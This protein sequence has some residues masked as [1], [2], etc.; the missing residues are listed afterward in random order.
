MV[1]WGVFLTNRCGELFEVGLVKFVL[2]NVFAKRDVS[3]L[4]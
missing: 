4:A 1:W 3:V 2:K